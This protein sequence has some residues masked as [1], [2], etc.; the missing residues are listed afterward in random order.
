MVHDIL[1]SLVGGYKV[2]EEQS[3]ST[4]RMWFIYTFSPSFLQGQFQSPMQKSKLMNDCPT[5]RKYGF[6][7][8]WYFYNI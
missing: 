8:C 3:G 5:S 6:I 4:M 2:L 7:I 1:C